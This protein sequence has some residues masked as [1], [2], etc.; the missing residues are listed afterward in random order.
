MTDSD[1]IIEA[2]FEV[3]I[4]QDPTDRLWYPMCMAANVHPSDYGYPN[5]QDVIQ[6]VITYFRESVR[7]FTGSDEG[8]IRVNFVPAA[9]SKDE[10]NLIQRIR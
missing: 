10:P 3:L 2:A 9:P 1:P 7:D 4:W 5:P 6:G 8:R